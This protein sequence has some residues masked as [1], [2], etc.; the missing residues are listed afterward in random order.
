[1]HS[2]RSQ[3]C[4]KDIKFSLYCPLDLQSVSFSILHM[5]VV[6]YSVTV[7]K[8]LLVCRSGRVICVIL[9]NMSYL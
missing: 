4:I 9:C 3:I 5:S 7:A 6:G 1:M 8:H 2:V